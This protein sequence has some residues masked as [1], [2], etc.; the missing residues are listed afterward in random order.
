MKIPFTGFAQKHQL[1]YSQKRMFEVT[2]C[3]H[4]R[5]RIE[6]V[7]VDALKFE[8]ELAWENYQKVLEEGKPEQKK[9]TDTVSQRFDT[10]TRTEDNVND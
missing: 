9:A 5:W 8:I 1:D 7:G 3:I 4:N 6:K 2:W 10:T